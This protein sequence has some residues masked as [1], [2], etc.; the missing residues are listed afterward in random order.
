MEF[1]VAA[2]KRLD[3][4]C[5]LYNG[6]RETQQSPSGEPGAPSAF[7]PAPQDGTPHCKATGVY[8][9]AK[10]SWPAGF[11]KDWKH[12]ETRINKKGELYCPT[13]IG[14][15]DEGNLI[16]CG[17]RAVEGENG[18]EEWDLNEKEAEMP[19]E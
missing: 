2:F 16:W 10:G 14:K 8:A 4:A 18:W 17:W 5:D 9:A 12:K 13:P 11:K 15:D 6:T 7:K 3:D 19:F 1:V